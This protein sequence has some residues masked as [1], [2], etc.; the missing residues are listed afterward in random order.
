MPLVL[1]AISVIV[2]LILMTKLKI[3][4]F[5]ALLVVAVGEV[6]ERALGG[7]A[8]GALAEQ[9]H[10]FGRVTLGLESWVL[11]QLIASPQA[12]AAG[13]LSGNPV[14]ESMASAISTA[15]RCPAARREQKRRAEPAGFC[16]LR[17]VL[18]GR[19]P[20]PAE[21]RLPADSA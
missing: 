19:P 4:G 8:L 20:G 9:S 5:V 13:I 6:G 12:G 1:V 2:L 21:L 15:S 17:D 10:Q 3:N 16:P 18:A 7:V 11:A 14:L